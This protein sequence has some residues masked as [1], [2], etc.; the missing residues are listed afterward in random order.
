M[1][2]ISIGNSD[3]VKL[4]GQKSNGIASTSIRMPQNNVPSSFW[5]GKGVTWQ[6]ASFDAWQIKEFAGTKQRMP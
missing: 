2:E 3:G 6:D 5:H 1:I 4:A